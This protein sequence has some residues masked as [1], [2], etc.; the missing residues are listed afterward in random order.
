MR[1]RNI[2]VILCITMINTLKKKSAILF[3]V[4]IVA[5]AAM[6]LIAVET[7]S[8][9]AAFYD[10]TDF[11]VIGYESFIDVLECNEETFSGK[12][13]RLFTDIDIDV[14][15]E[16]YRNTVLFPGFAGTFDGNGHTINGIRKNMFGEIA[17]SAT[18]RDIV[19]T[20]AELTSSVALAATN[21][22]LISNVTFYGAQTASEARGTVENNYGVMTGI[23]S[24]LSVTVTSKSGVYLLVGPNNNELTDSFFAGPLYCSY[25]SGP[26]RCSDLTERVVSDGETAALHVSS[27]DCDVFGDSSDLTSSAP[28]VM[29]AS[30]ITL[31]DDLAS[32][33]SDLVA[34]FAFTGNYEAFCPENG[35]QAHADYT[36]FFGGVKDLFSC[37]TLSAARSGSGVLAR[38]AL[39]GLTDPYLVSVG[40]DGGY[41]YSDYQR[42]A[43]RLFG[44]ESVQTFLSKVSSVASTCS[45]NAAGA[46]TSSVSE[47]LVYNGAVFTSSGSF[48]FPYLFKSPSASVFACV[49]LGADGK[50]SL[51]IGDKED[52]FSMT[53]LSSGTRY[54]ESSGRCV[55]FDT[56]SACDAYTAT[57]ADNGNGTYTKTTAYK[58][59]DIYPYSGGNLTN[60]IV[61]N[62]AVFADMETVALPVNILPY[63][64]N[65][66]CC[67]GVYT[68]NSSLPEQPTVAYALQSKASDTDV[69][70]ENVDLF[71]GTLSSYLI[72]PIRSVTDSYQSVCYNEGT[73]VSPSLAYLTKTIDSAGNTADDFLSWTPSDFNFIDGYYPVQKTFLFGGASGSPVQLS[74]AEDVARLR[75]LV[76]KN[77]SSTA[78]ATLTAPID[79]AGRGRVRALIGNVD[80][81][82]FGDYPL[83]N[84]P[85]DLFGDGFG[86][87]SVFTVRPDQITQFGG[88]PASVSTVAVTEGSGTQDDPYVIE[89]AGQLVSFVNDGTKNISGK[90]AVISTDIV[91]NARPN[92]INRLSL[93]S[94]V[95][96]ATLDGCGHTLF[97]LCAEPFVGTVAGTLKNMNIYAPE[98]SGRDAAAVVCLIN[99]GVVSDVNVYGTGEYE[100]AF[101]TTN[102]GTITRSRNE[103]AADHAFCETNNGTISYSVNVASSCP[104][105]DG[106]D[107]SGCAECI[108]VSGT[109]YL[110]INGAANAFE[111]AGYLVLE[112]NGYDMDVFAYRT[113][114]LNSTI[115]VLRRYGEEYKTETEIEVFLPD[116]SDV[117]FGD[118]YTTGDFIDT[119]D[120]NVIL[121]WTYRYGEETTVISVDDMDDDEYVKEVGAYL[122]T[123]AV[124]ETTTTL[125]I[126]ITRAFNILKADCPI[127][128]N[129]VTF[130]NL[131]GNAG[132]V[133]TGESVL[134]SAIEL[135]PNADNNVRRLIDEY[136]YAFSYAYTFGGESVAAE[137][138]VEV[139]LYAQSFTAISKNYKNITRTARSIEIK[140]APLAVTVTGSAE[141]R[142]GYQL[143]FAGF[144]AEATFLGKDADANMTLLSAVADYSS[145][146][147]TDYVVGQNAGTEASVWFS[148]DGISL[149]NYAFTAS[150]YAGGT[151]TV[152]KAPIAQGDI[153]FYGAT[154]I[155]NGSYEGT[156]NGSAHVLAAT[157][158]PSGVGYAYDVTPSFVNAGSY[159]VSLIVDD[160]GTDDNYE[161][162]VLTVDVVIHK[163]ELTVTATDVT[164][165]YGYLIDYDDF[166]F[167]VE[168]LCGSDT[169][170]ILDGL[171][172]AAAPEAEEGARPGYG[173]YAI[174]FSAD[175]Y[176]TNNYVL[177]AVPGVFTVTKISLRRL[178]VNNTNGS[179]NYDFDDVDRV[180]DGQSVDLRG[181]G[182]TYFSEQG[183]GVQISY[184]Y[185][186]NG[187]AAERYVSDAGTYVVTAT[188]TPES[189]D[190]AVTVYTRTYL[191]R[192]KTTSVYFVAADGYE[193]NFS[194]GDYTYVYVPGGTVNYGAADYCAYRSTGLPADA[195]VQFGGDNAVYVGTYTKTLLYLGDE[196]HEPCSATATVTVA[197]CPVTVSVTRDYSYTASAVLPV[198]DIE[199]TDELTDGSFT[200]SY[201]DG[202]GQHPSALRDAGTYTLSLSCKNGNYTLVQNTYEV[203]VVPLAVSVDI[204]S[205]DFEYGTMGEY[206]YRNG[207]E[208]YDFVIGVNTVTL[209]NYV[210]SKTDYPALVYDVTIDLIFRLYDTDFARYF[211]AGSYTPRSV[212]NTNNFTLSIGSSAEVIVRKRTLTAKWLI[213]NGYGFEECATGGFTITYTGAS[214]NGMVS[215]D[216]EG[217]AEGEGL[218][219]VD[220]SY[221][222][223]KRY[224][225]TVIN[226]ILTVGEYVCGLSIGNRLNYVMESTT[227]TFVVRVQKRPISVYVADA[228]VQQRERF[229]GTLVSA[230]AEDLVGVDTGKRL[231]ELDGYYLRY[232]CSYNENVNTAS[233]GDRYSID[234]QITLDNYQPT[235]VLNENNS[236]ATL[237]V[238]ANPLPEYNLSGRTYVYDGTPKS[239]SISGVDESVMVTYTNNEQVNVG[240][241][242]VV[243]RVRYPSG[244]ESVVSAELVI[245]KATPVVEPETIYVVY[246]EGAVLTDDLIRGRAYVGTG[247]EIGGSYSFSGEK[248]LVAGEKRYPVSFTPE[249]T[250]NVNAIDS[251]LFV[252]VKC[253]VIDGKL[254]QSSNEYFFTGA[255]TIMIKDK[256]VIELDRDSI[257]EISDKVQLYQ[258]DIPVTNFLFNGPG[259]QKIEIRY[260]GETVYRRNYTIEVE[261]EKE[262]PTEPVRINE[263]MFDVSSLLIDASRSVIY[264]GADGGRLALDQ[265]YLDDYDLYVNGIKIGSSGINI[266]IGSQSVILEIRNKVIGT[267]YKK[268][269]A[270][271]SE[272]EIPSDNPPKKVG[273]PD[274]VIYIIIAVAGVVVVGGLL[275]LLL[276]GRH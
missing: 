17:S 130:S 146:F 104:S 198:L 236:A 155:L 72:E 76:R 79:Y 106:G 256:V 22:G 274:Y 3:L 9:E 188:V 163:A 101:V 169:E 132:I 214:R 204:P 182:I 83:Y 276:R 161:E 24:Y 261:T 244:R 28:S 154:A 259:E 54:L 93:S 210:V 134:A 178:Y 95:L 250:A 159:S 124:K 181:S 53:D 14:L 122:L 245:A 60:G 187:V 157:G 265:K 1:A 164:K 33:F 165:E 7:R 205:F 232:V 126:K 100:S 51:F 242:I 171:H 66:A 239:L 224:N 49:I 267:A 145:R 48:V 140:K 13:V 217:F 50:A 207:D 144:T 229:T 185:E 234:V 180:Y 220:V 80:L 19:F 42:L 26:W 127:K 47:R 61:E 190:Y 16:E 62:C 105:F 57:I 216:V 275:L 139:G 251:D 81:N 186:K 89:S 156:Y 77:G 209:K 248:Q 230:R 118:Y 21:Y 237:T 91:L 219:D 227:A 74:K 172:P 247:F 273:L 56:P 141:V 121:E 213:D 166:S 215:Y 82:I 88:T 264:V 196:N 84:A 260:D 143:S 268:Q 137:D 69:L 43:A 222:V 249:D 31:F 201:T 5:I 135:D 263:K 149:K 192:K 179:G 221:S 200:Y 27:C 97:G 59:L 23:G 258:N 136:G 111:S 231:S 117:T 202:Y 212:L 109:D 266:D 64:Q 96:N 162:L 199:G 183:I 269:F 46:A 252:T 238:V 197:P 94:A 195:E 78:Y 6:G 65:S 235:V 176:E 32:L 110:L 25:Y 70:T 41:A 36:A 73:F 228:T 271:R 177:T 52:A 39:I 90:Y 240:R 58:Y 131:S 55:L 206:V 114:E 102:N 147:R 37:S 150:S 8:A 170:S 243:A 160:D 123:I 194:G 184:G 133:Y 233:V 45:T 113:G 175:A 125:P 211:P 255:D 262:E 85:T 254:L 11:A 86:V 98:A 241:Y 108:S 191:I 174:V 168:G 10:K 142:Y 167:G 272:T 148:T 99:N 38:S 30:S 223:V 189:E 12:T 226:T 29:P 120:P 67:S 44:H 107:G 128:A 115:P 257:A 4:F 129:N 71:T 34:D 87:T 103:L 68:L 151:V 15:P 193:N 203:V 116:P 173:E 112:E 119:T 152:T 63:L 158:I 225:A 138:I 253:F 153:V 35:T 270:V 208:E 218:R 40:G 92:E 18:V 20:N 75:M 2:H 246:K